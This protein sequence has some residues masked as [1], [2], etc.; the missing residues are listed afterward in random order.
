MSEYTPRKQFLEF[1]QRPNRWACIVAHRRAGKTVACVM[2]LLTRALAS[3][4][5]RPQYA[6]LAPLF[7]QAKQIAWDYIKEYGRDIIK[8]KNESELYVDLIN[9]ARVFVLGADNPD[10]LRGLY[11]DGVVMDEYGDMKERVFSEVIRPA[12]SDRKGW[13]VFIGTP[14]GE[15][16][17]Y[18]IYQESTRN[19]DW[20]SMILR[21][22][23]SG[24]LDA[25]EIA[26]MSLTMNENQLAQELDCSFNAAIQG[27]IY[28]KQLLEADRDGRITKVPYDPASE[29]FTAWDLGWGD[30]TTIWWLQFIG[31][32]LRWLDCYDASG[33]QLGHYVKIVKDKPYVY[34]GHY[35]PHDGAHGNIRGDSVS[36]QLAQMGLQ[37]TVLQR[38]SDVSVGIELL[39][40]TI[41]YSVFD[42]RNCASGLRALRQHQY[43]YDDTKKVYSKTPFHDWTSHYADA[44]RY[45][46]IAASQQKGGVSKQKP[47]SMR[48]DVN[49]YMGV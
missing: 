46:A 33:E 30:S 29:V 27:A 2:E 15:N 45:A 36:K 9:G 18:D 8:N 10:R 39:R 32:E 4:K 48:I 11:L 31:R 42:E 17:F 25:E 40:Q 28:A 22:S 1:H 6:Y 21:A 34:G 49:S 5:N 14:K 13:A 23:E 7:V 3:K 16:S 26:D 35:L 19:K 41:A 38:E 47:I 12:L 20:F 44:A 24:I 43:K 37:N